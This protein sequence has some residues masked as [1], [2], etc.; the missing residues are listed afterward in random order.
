MVHLGQAFQNFAGVAESLT[1]KKKSRDDSFTLSNDQ[2]A[3]DAAAT[4]ID[5][6]ALG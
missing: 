5:G 2:D 6:C 4:P 1:F 3:E